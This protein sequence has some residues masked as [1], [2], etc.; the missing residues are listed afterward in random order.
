MGLDRAPPSPQ[1]TQSDHASYLH[2]TADVTDGESVKAAISDALARFG[3]I[4]AA[5]CCAGVLHAERIVGRHGAAS[6]EAFQRVIDINVN[7]TFNVVRLVAEAMSKGEPVEPDGERGVI[8]MTSSIAASDG[9][10]GQAAYAASKGA[11]AS[12]TLPLARDLGRFGIRVA[13]IAP[14]V[15]D[16][17]MMLAAPEKVRQPLWEQTIFP[18]RFGMPDE[19]AALALHVLE[20]RMINGSVVRLDAALRM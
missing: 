16:T 13:S 11:V 2:A 9:Q 20:N 3:K 12:M 17:P 1:L 6:L 7:G 15:F 5:I 18:K 4:Q 14:G 19:F 8:I 10:I